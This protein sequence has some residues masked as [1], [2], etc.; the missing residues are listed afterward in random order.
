MFWLKSKAV[1]NLLAT[2]FLVMIVVYLSSV[3]LPVL[4]VS[5]GFAYLFLPLLKISPNVSKNISLSIV[6][7]V[8]I[9]FIIF[10]LFVFVPFTVS[11]LLSMLQSI[12]DIVVALK[13]VANDL[14]VKYPQYIDI[15]Q[16]NVFYAKVHTWFTEHGSSGFS[17]LLKLIPS[18]FS[19]LLFLFLLPVLVFLFLKDSEKIASWCCSL[20]PKGSDL[21]K[22]F[23]KNIDLQLGSYVK[24]KVVE[25]FIVFVVSWILFWGLGLKYSFIL[26]L[27]AGLS[28]FIPIVG[29]VIAT[30]PVL[31]VAFW[32]YGLSDWFYLVVIVHLIILLIDSNVLVPWLFANRLNL[33]PAV[34][35]LSVLFFGELF[36]FWGMFFAIPLASIIN[37]L[38]NMWKSNVAR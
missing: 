36:G 21:I 14:L 10:M 29:A 5:A 1:M 26:A 38:I 30:V 19:V 34:I 31:F 11:Q 17:I 23:F 7:L 4:L 12:P 33:H 20:L 3:Y 25:I 32:Q 2:I 15:S 22:N 35:I 24:G 16:I 9:A 6:M 8:F 37:L 18:V 28:V 27:I 13:A